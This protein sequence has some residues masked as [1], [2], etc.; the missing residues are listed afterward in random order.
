MA[1]PIQL[2]EASLRLVTQLR[3]TELLQRVGQPINRPVVRTAA[4]WRD[5]LKRICSK[6][7]ANARI[8]WGNQLSKAMCARFSPEYQSWNQIAI[9]SN[10]LLDPIIHSAVDRIDAR[11][12]VRKLAKAH[13]FYSIRIDLGGAIQELEYRHLIPIA[14]HQS[15]LPWYLDGHMPCDWEGDSLDGQLFVF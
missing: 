1:V 4:N 9:A 10:E 5:A 12:G 13:L 6:R 7:W 8:V 15:L 11:L 14:F 2:C 3:R